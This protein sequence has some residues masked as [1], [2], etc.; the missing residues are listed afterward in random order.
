VTQL[1]GDLTKAQRVQ[2]L[3]GTGTQTFSYGCLFLGA[4]PLGAAWPRGRRV[5]SVDRVN[6]PHA[7]E[8]RALGA[9]DYQRFDRINWGTFFRTHPD[10]PD[11]LVVRIPKDPALELNW[12][13]RFLGRAAGKTPNYLVV[14][15]RAGEVLLRQSSVY[16]AWVKRFHRAGYEGVL[17]H[18]DS[19]S[20]GSPT[21]GG[22]FVTLYYRLSLGLED[23]LALKLVGDLELLP[24]SFQNCLMPVGAPRKLW[25][26]KGRVCQPVRIP[27]KPNH[28]GS[29]MQHP[30]VDPSG[31]ALL[32]PDLFI[33][34][35][36]GM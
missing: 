35:A 13:E 20:C 33:T 36:S 17:K 31:P 3:G 23:D 29:L 24:R 2:P 5:F 11:V 6:R 12:E 32:D 22:F 28:L 14:V 30:V 26:P 15:E 27:Q 1:C 10:P 19:S 25:A 34:L 21:W 18:V 8:G 9:F 16:R 7:V 4:D